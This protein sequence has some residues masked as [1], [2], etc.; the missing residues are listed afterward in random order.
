M[1]VHTIWWYRAKGLGM[2]CVGP[3][4]H[5]RKYR[6]ASARETL[7][8]HQAKGVGYAMSTTEELK[9]VQAVAA[10]TGIVLDPVY[11]GKALHGLMRDIAAAPKEW[12]GRRLLFVHTGGLL[13]MYD[14]IDQLQPLVEEEGMAFRMAV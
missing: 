13:G 11:S 3:R 14:K 6:S 1:S 2:S 5:S 12:A 10:A 4:D 9:T 8:A 7:I